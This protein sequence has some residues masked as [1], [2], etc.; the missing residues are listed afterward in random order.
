MAGEEFWPIEATSIAG[1]RLGIPQGLLLS[2]LDDT[3]AAQFSSA[4]AMLRKADARLTDETLNL[5]DDMT[6]ANRIGGFAAIEGYAIH[7]EILAKKGQDYDQFVRA[8]FER[9]RDVLAA[10][11]VAFTRQRTRLARAMDERLEGFD[12]IALP[13]TAIVAPKISEVATL[14]NFLV[15]QALVVRNTS[16]VNFFDLCAISV[17][18]PRQGGLPVGLML[19]ARNGHDRHLFRIAAA[20][21]RLLAA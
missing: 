14:E 12:A 4:T 15:K 19:V 9:A 20:V 8:R 17:P 7:R 6:T 10:D 11:Y 1:L 21:E 13:T 5:L 18:L 2:N 3:V 16:W